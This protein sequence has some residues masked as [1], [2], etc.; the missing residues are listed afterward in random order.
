[1]RRLTA[2]VSLSSKHNI[3]SASASRRYFANPM[4]RPCTRVPSFYPAFLGFFQNDDSSYFFFTVII[5]RSP[6][7]KYLSFRPPP[8]LPVPPHIMRVYI[9]ELGKYVR[10]GLVAKHPN[11]PN[12]FLFPQLSGIR[13]AT[14]RTL[15][16]G[17]MLLTSRRGVWHTT[18]SIPFTCAI[19]VYRSLVCQSPLL[20]ISAEEETHLPL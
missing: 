15:A 8:H 13:K 3:P 16:I 5:T 11:H 17:A 14:A 20:H 7:G 1:M 2:R 6:A 10:L 4:L 19:T 12:H 9:P 18:A